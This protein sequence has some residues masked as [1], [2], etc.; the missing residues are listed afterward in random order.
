MH[1]KYENIICVEKETKTNRK[2]IILK[3]LLGRHIFCDIFPL[4]ISFSKKLA[5]SNLLSCI[6]DHSN[7]YITLYDK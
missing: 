2:K 5:C 3:Y 1:R 4:V 6:D 7:V